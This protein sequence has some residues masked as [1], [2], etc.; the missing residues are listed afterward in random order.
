MRG[1]FLRAS[2]AGTTGYTP[3]DSDAA[4]YITAVEGQDGQALENGVREA[5]D[6]FVIGCKTDGIW[7]AIKACCILA[8]ARTLNGIL[9]PLVGAAPTNVSSNFVI[10][11]YGRKIGLLGNGSN[12]QLNTN[13]ANNVDPQNSRH[14]SVFMTTHQSR[15][16]TRAA[17]GSGAA[18]AGE[19][20]LLTTT[21]NRFY[22]LSVSAGDPGFADAR[23][24]TGFW[25]ASRTG[26]SSTSGRYNGENVTSATVSTTP[27]SANLRI[28]SRGSDF[29]DARIAFYS[30]GE[31]LDLVLLDSRVT[32]L[33][34]A[35]DAAIP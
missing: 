26:N 23:T 10:G 15:G 22:R 24:L 34:N 28:F 20:M 13:R 9:T 14:L 16:A 2:L 35:I 11:D 29:S 3:T 25:G 21:T 1:H 7:S 31:A 8:G 30:A 18:A 27:T 12:K 4:A 5:I 17:M 6:N 33:I 19:S 32:T